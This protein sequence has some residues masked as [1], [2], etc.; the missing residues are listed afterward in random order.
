[1]NQEKIGKFIAACRKEHGMTQVQFAE[2]LGITNMVYF[3]SKGQIIS[4]NKRL[5]S[6]GC[7]G[8]SASRASGVR[9]V[10]WRRRYYRINFSTKEP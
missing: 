2:K 4:D 9:K 8:R 10:I 7:P 6:P 3:H 5:H 1:M